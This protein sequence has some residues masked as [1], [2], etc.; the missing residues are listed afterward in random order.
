MKPNI[1]IGLPTMSQVNT[2]LMIVILKWVANAG[3]KYD[4][5]IY[6]TF[7][8]QPVDNARNQIVDEFLKSDCTH[9]FFIDSDTI[10]PDDAIEKLMSHNRDI[11]SGLTPIV[12]HNEKD[13]FHTG[14]NC[15]DMEENRLIPNIGLKKIKGAGASCLLIKKSVFETMKPPYFRFLYADDNGKATMVSEDIYFMAMAIGNGIEA[16]CDTSVVCKHY[17]PIMW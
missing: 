8:V 13:G 3:N 11:I 6:P 17:K 14:M 4:L 12:Y 15:T 2:A 10:P 7:S 9:L 1:L 5:N 16:Y